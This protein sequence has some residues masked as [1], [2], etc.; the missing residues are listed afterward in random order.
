MFGAFSHPW[1][2]VI[3]YVSY[4]HVLFLGFYDATLE[5][6]FVSTKIFLTK[7]VSPL[8]LDIRVSFCVYHYAA[9]C[10]VWE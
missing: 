2:M 9:K 8:F 7:V 5:E 10:L 1:S 4:M 3:F 6:V